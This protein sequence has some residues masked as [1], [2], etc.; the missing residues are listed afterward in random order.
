MIDF[1][2]RS[3][4]T[5]MTFILLGVIIIVG[6][7]DGHATNNHAR[8]MYQNGYHIKDG[9]TWI[10]KEHKKYTYIYEC[11]K[12]GEIFHCSIKMNDN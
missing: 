11:T 7:I 6:I 3:W 10:L 12:C 4:V 2:K 9:G 5:L 8:E 1:I